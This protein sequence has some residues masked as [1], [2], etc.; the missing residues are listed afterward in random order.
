MVERSAGPQTV[1]FLNRVGN[2]IESMEMEGQR[3]L[4]MYNIIGTLVTERDDDGTTVF[5]ATHSRKD[6]NSL[7]AIKRMRKGA[8]IPG[9]D[10]IS[11]KEALSG[12]TSDR[13]VPL[14]ES[15]HD[16]QAA[17]LV[18]EFMV[19]GTIAELPYRHEYTRSINFNDS[20]LLHPEDVAF[21]MKEALDGL[22]HLHTRGFVHGLL[23]PSCFLLD[24]NGHL[25]LS[26]LGGATRIG[27]GLHPDLYSAPFM[28][29]AEY[30]APELLDAADAS[31]CAILA[32]TASDLWSIGVIIYE[33]LVGETPFAADHVIH[34]HHRIRQHASQASDHERA[35]ES[36]LLK[37]P[38]IDRQAQDLLARLLVPAHSRISIEEAKKHHFF[39]PVRERITPAFLPYVER[40]GP[41]SAATVC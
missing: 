23:S 9:N 18:T 40:S 24:R 29:R 22:G 8:R 7:V 27:T 17:Y 32:D 16:A 19:G 26:G 37:H 39:A 33:L 21:Y 30:L 36:P 31:P 1:A 12:G 5:L 41:I 10:P 4:S 25:R 20:C 34:T 35:L 38:R 11:A 14:I 3:R 13:I 15:F 6:G 2:L 28:S